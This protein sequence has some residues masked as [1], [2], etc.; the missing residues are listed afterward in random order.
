MN[1]YC[2]YQMQETTKKHN[3]VLLEPQ[4]YEQLYQEI[5]SMKPAFEYLVA[6]KKRKAAAGMASLRSGH[7]GG[8][9]GGVSG[10]RDERML[11]QHAEKVYEWL[12]KK[13]QSRIRMLIKWQSAGGL[14]FVAQAYHRIQQCWVYHGNTGIADQGVAVSKQ[15]FADAIIHRHREGGD[16]GMEAPEADADWATT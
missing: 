9:G 3:K 10:A 8:G 13:K 6:G 1:S 12:D 15:E 2:A 7:S 5:D 16:E 14:S 4:I 11:R